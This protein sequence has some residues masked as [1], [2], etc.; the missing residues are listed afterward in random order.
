MERV[1]I[2]N[3][4]RVFSAGYDP[5]ARQMEVEYRSGGV[6]VYDNVDQDVYDGLIEASSAGAYIDSVIK[7]GGYIFRRV[8]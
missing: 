1:P 6:Y 4:S 3:S 8:G 2:D 7:G 5:E